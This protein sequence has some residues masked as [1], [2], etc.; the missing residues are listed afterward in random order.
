MKLVINIVM[1]RISLFYTVAWICRKKKGFPVCKKEN[2]AG[3]QA[4]RKRGK[5]LVPVHHTLVKSA[6]TWSVLVNIRRK[7]LESSAGFRKR[8]TSRSPRGIYIYMCA[9][10]RILICLMIWRFV[11]RSCLAFSIIPRLIQTRRCHCPRLK[12]VLKFQASSCSAG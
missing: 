10:D 9:S 8:M 5:D 7:A 3:L 12:D 1:K 6:E 11:P 2:F 4:H